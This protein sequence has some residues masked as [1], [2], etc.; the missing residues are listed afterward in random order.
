M[1]PLSRARRWR[2][3]GHPVLESRLSPLAFPHFL[4]QVPA[5]FADTK[6]MESA[7][8]AFL[9]TALLALGWLHPA[10]LR[11]E[12]YFLQAGPPPLRFIEAAKTNALASST[13]NGLAANT[14]GLAAGAAQPAQTNLAVPSATQTSTD[15]SEIVAEPMELSVLSSSNSVVGPD[16]T[17]LSAS[18]LLVVTPQMLA[19]LL[20]PI[21]GRPGQPATNAAP[22]EPM[23]FTPPTLK[24]PSSEATYQTR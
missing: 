16:G 17:P 10:G 7:L 19:D 5:T 2:P 21:P 4:P 22:N 15:G 8:R 23:I 11:A 3:S 18:E 13:A 6:E 24:P 12:V 14:N 9:G 20:K 1:A